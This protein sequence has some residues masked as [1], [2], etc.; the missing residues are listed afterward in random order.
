MSYLFGDIPYT[1]VGQNPRKE[2]HAGCRQGLI[3]QS[4]QGSG[5][6]GV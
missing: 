2:G 3:V 5:A 1:F 6:S 4:F